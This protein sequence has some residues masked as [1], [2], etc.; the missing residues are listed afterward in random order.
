MMTKS[1]LTRYLKAAVELEQRV[2]TQAVTLSE[3]DDYYNSLG[4]PTVFAPV[5]NPHKPSTTDFLENAAVIPI[6]LFIA[7]PLALFGLFLGFLDLF[8][9]F[10]AML[11]GISGLLI[12]ISIIIA[13]NENSN[14][15]EDYEAALYNAEEQKRQQKRLI[16][17]DAKR[18]ASENK[19]KERILEQR[20][21]LYDKW[22]ETNSVLDKLY[23][24]NIIYS[25][26]RNFVAV[27]SFYEY[28]L[29]GRC[30]QLE[31]HEG[32]Y[33]IF[34]EEKRLD[35]IVGKL[36][37]IITRLEQIE[38]NQYTLYE[39]IN[40]SNETANKLVNNVAVLTSK[41]DYISSQTEIAA[42]NTQWAAEELNT[43]K[44]IEILK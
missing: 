39:A 36:D 38:E 27:C 28:L 1:D 41:A 43:I 4:I 33:N 42:K 23:S 2:Y 6:A 40:Q 26:Y 21:L 32:A 30:S 19:K 35:L 16:E 15:R 31:G 17:D 22:E 11:Y 8:P 12:I 3:L 24:L 5:A 44:W 25:K 37:D 14:S 7:I 10:R 29:S 9:E 13:I 18:V 20:Q 34:E